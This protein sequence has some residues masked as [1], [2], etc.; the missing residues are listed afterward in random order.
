MNITSA[1]Y[2]KFEGE[3]QNIIIVCDG[4]TYSVPLKEGNI[5]YAEILK[6]VKEGKLTIK[7]AE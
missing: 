6:Q 7:E 3:N 1:K 4:I 2:F 5:H